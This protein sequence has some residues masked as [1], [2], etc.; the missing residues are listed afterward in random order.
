V[1]FTGVLTGPAPSGKK[2]I[3]NHLHS[4]LRNVIEVEN[5]IAIAKL[6]NGEANKN[7]NCMHSL[8]Q[9]Y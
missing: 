7:Y 2:E 9:F 6:S 8:V 1:P 4:S 3:F 5:I